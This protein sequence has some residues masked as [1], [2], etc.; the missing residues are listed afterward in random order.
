MT[1]SETTN[2]KFSKGDRVK[3][4]PKDAESRYYL[5]IRMPEDRGGTIAFQPREGNRVA[6][7]WDGA[8]RPRYI[9]P[10]FLEL[11]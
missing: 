11:A 4:S 6:V 2:R 9:D 7:W 8:S 3:L 10:D 1:Q 5:G